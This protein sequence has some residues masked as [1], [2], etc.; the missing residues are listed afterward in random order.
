[1]IYRTRTRRQLTIESL[2][3]MPSEPESKPFYTF[4]DGDDT[5]E[6]LNDTFT[7]VLSRD[8]RKNARIAAQM[9]FAI[10]RENP[11]LDVWYVNTYAGVALMKEAFAKELEKSGMPLPEPRLPMDDRSS[12]EPLPE[13]ATPMKPPK[14]T[15]SLDEVIALLKATGKNWF[16][17]DRAELIGNN[18]TEEEKAWARSLEW[19]RKYDDEDKEEDSEEDESED[20]SPAMHPAHPSMHPNFFIHDVPLG[21]WNTAMLRRDIERRG[22]GTKNSAPVTETTPQPPPLGSGGGV[23]AV[24]VLNSFEFA[25]MNRGQ[26]DR[27]VMQLIELRDQ[28]GLTFVVFSHE[29][30]RDLGAG[31]PGR[32]PLGALAAKAGAVVRLNDP[33]EHLIRSRKS[34]AGQGN[35]SKYSGNDVIHEAQMRSRSIPKTDAE[36]MRLAREADDFPDYHADPWLGKIQKTGR[37]LAF[38]ARSP[39][40]QRYY[41]EHPDFLFTRGE[42]PTEYALETGTYIAREQEKKWFI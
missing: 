19:K 17:G 21:T 27:M 3:E 30:K 20:A 6:V 18:V 23:G 42:E 14:P 5:I 15:L 34:E 16:I 25:S 10:A 40:V 22:R 36:R 4:K 32:G 37:E 9:S 13:P 12:A 31:I 35:A 29:M 7:L 24:V 1:M 8:V 11:D 2:F 39:I 38:I 26:K 33:F 28:L 41:L